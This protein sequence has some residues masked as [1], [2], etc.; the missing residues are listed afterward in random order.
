MFEICLIQYVPT[1]ESVRLVGNTILD[2]LLLVRADMVKAI[3]II[4]LHLF[5]FVTQSKTF[6][7]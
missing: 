6:P 3:K 2:K 1:R 5:Y 4:F 7:I